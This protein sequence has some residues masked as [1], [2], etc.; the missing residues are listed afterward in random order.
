MKLFPLKLS[1]TSYQTQLTSVKK[2]HL[3]KKTRLK[4]AVIQ[5]LFL[6][7]KP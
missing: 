2:L 1:T 5:R 4:L 3:I 7:N 6:Q